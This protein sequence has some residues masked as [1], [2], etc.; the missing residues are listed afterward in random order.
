M[1]VKDRVGHDATQR[2][3]RLLLPSTQ[4]ALSRNGIW[5]DT[6]MA[7]LSDRDLLALAGIGPAGRQDIR[8]HFPRHDA[9]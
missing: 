3:F 1:D 7:K 9:G 4:R 8:Q 5:T 2:R 6:A